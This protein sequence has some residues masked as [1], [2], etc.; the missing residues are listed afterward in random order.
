MFAS[1]NE[2]IVYSIA[3]PR[4]SSF[5]KLDRLM[6]EGNPGAKGKEKIKDKYINASAIKLKVEEG[7][8]L[9]VK[10]EV[11]SRVK[12]NR[13]KARTLAKSTTV[14]I[15]NPGSTLNACNETAKLINYVGDP[16]NV[17]IALCETDSGVVRSDGVLSGTAVTSVADIGGDDSTITISRSGK[18]GWSLA[19]FTPNTA[20]ILMHPLM[21][22]HSN[23]R[24][25]VSL[26]FRRSS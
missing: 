19:S 4:K 25:M 10:A 20:G 9:K 14:V 26:Q 13:Q 17:K 7:G 5:K 1:D 11:K 2:D 15:F 21:E 23:A 16:L 8:E 12:K 3:S 22:S 24:L 18:D 6:E